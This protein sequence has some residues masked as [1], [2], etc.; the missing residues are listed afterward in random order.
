VII[1]ND[2]LKKKL[3]ISKER[4]IIFE[5]N[6]KELETAF[7]NLNNILSKNSIIKL[8]EQP[9]K[10]P[11]DLVSLEQRTA[12]KKFSLINNNDEEKK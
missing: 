1:D 9:S 4:I 2:D 6:I 10:N 11:S 3:S 12:Q 7:D 8:N 5:K